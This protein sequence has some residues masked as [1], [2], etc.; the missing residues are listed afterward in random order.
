MIDLVATLAV[1]CGL[2]PI[3]RV[4]R[5]R[6]PIADTPLARRDASAARGAVGDVEDAADGWL[7]VDFGRG[8]IA[9]SPDEL[10]VVAW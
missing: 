2:T 7:W 5:A 4:V 3:P 6:C 10:D 9:C 1:C 8:T